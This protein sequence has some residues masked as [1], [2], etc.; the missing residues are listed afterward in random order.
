MV[1]RSSFNFTEVLHVMGSGPGWRCG[2]RAPGL[3]LTH[4]SYSWINTHFCQVFTRVNTTF[5]RCSHTC[6]LTPR[7]AVQTLRNGGPTSSDIDQTS[8]N[9]A[10]TRTNS[11][12]DPLFISLR[13]QSCFRGFS[14]SVPDP[15]LASPPFLSSAGS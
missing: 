11:N 10:W 14:L 6:V 1:G 13:S 15:T 3:T 7:S 4:C 2:S 9:R 12:R 5:A 8:E